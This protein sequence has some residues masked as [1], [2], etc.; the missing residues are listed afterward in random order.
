MLRLF[1]V[2]AVLCL[3][4]FCQQP[5]KPPEDTGL[6]FRTETKLALV[7]FHVVNK[8]KYVRDLKAEDIQLL[9]DGAAQKL[10]LF[11][12]PAT[13]RRAVP[14]EVIMLFDVSL[15]VMNEDLLDS[16]A[17]KETL[18]D[19]LGPSDGISSPRRSRRYRTI[20]SRAARSKSSCLSVG[21]TEW[22]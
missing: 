21:S 13:L 3:P 19:G 15:S 1:L 20:S 22:G 9:E 17:L 11:E 12:A 6:V 5:Q 4:A 18:L 14:V 8:G 16:F 2:A 10:V 7:P